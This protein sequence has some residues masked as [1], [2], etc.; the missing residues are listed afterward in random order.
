MDIKI[1]SVTD[2]GSPEL[3]PLYKVKIDG[4]FIALIQGS[5]SPIKIKWVCSPDRVPGFIVP[6]TNAISAEFKSAF[7]KAAADTNLD[8]NSV[9]AQYELKIK[10]AC[11]KGLCFAP[12]GGNPDMFAATRMA[13]VPFNR[14]LVTQKY[15]EVEFFNDKHPDIQGPTDDPELKAIHEACAVGLVWANADE[16]ATSTIPDTL[17]NR[18]AVR[19]QAS[20]AIWFANDYF[21]DPDLVMN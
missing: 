3:S 8:L 10:T 17:E 4:E 14:K 5:N 19:G 9:N 1:E 21:S 2:T 18:E 16:F 20:G 12:K 11:E 7:F 15:G 13:D 6:V